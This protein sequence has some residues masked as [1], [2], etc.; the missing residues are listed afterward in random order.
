MDEESRRKLRREMGMV[1][2]GSA[3]F[4]SM[5]VLENVM[6]PM[7]MLTKKSFAE[8]K[9]AS[10]EVIKRHEGQLTHCSNHKA[11]HRNT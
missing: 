5:S 7:K 10:E 1:F 2:Q 9:C 4:D 6:F 8:I 3:L 11:R